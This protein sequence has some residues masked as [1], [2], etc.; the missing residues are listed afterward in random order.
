MNFPRIALAALGAFV[1]YFILGGLLAAPPA[2]RNEFLK[3]PGVYRTK[4][5]MMKVMPGGMA[6]M[7]VSM[8]VLA[9]LY[10]MVYKG[11]SGLTEGAR[12]GALIGAFVVCAF[13]FHNYVNLNVGLTLTF[14]QSAVYFILWLVIGIVI[15]LIYRLPS[16]L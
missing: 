10:A 9:V 5:A 11:G 12:F 8:L 14:Q 1:A 4:E 16:T 7:F 3:Y 6:A 13:V 15:G 2:L